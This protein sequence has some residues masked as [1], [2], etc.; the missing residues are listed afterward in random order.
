MDEPT[1]ERTYCSVSLCVYSC[2]WAGYN[3]TPASVTS[4]LAHDTDDIGRSVCRLSG[5]FM[6][7]PLDFLFFFIY[8]PL[9]GFRVLHL[10]SA[11]IIFECVPW[12]DVRHV[13]SCRNVPPQQVPV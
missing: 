1:E 5:F 6:Q 13:F 4:S 12:L 3:I 10:V 9:I 8:N 2:D 7:M 11:N